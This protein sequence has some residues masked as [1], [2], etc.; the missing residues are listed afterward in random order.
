MSPAPQ[1]TILIIGMCGAGVAAYNALAPSLPP[2]HR[3]VAVNREDFAYWPIGG[4]RAAVVPGWE[5]KI[6]V[7]FKGLT[8][9]KKGN[10]VLGGSEVVHLDLE[11]KVAV[12]DE[13]RQELD[14]SKE[15]HFDYV[16]IATGSE[17]AIPCRPAPGVRTI[18][19]LKVSLQA[20]QRDI[21]AS[22]KVLI[23]GGGPVGI[24][25]AGELISKFGK[26]KQITLLTSAPGLYTD[27][28][29]K[30][31]LGA[32]L[33]KTLIDNGVKLVFG[34]KAF[35]GDLTTGK[36]NSHVLV[37]HA[38]GHNEEIEPDF[39][40]V[41]TGGRPNTSLFASSLLSSS[42]PHR[43]VV[44]RNLQLPAYP[45]AYAIGDVMDIDSK[46]TAAAGAQGPVVAKNVLAALGKGSKVELKDMATMVVVPIGADKGAGQ[47]M[48]MVV[49]GK[50]TSMIKG[51]TLFLS[52]FEKAYAPKSKKKFGIF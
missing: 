21:Q 51:K 20:L 31:A 36:V 34:A 1:E 16:I 13:A 30:P 17:Y 5:D 22:K 44:N 32:S 14:G 24:E 41:G 43:L 33:A 4:L 6:A 8:D 27:P 26:T 23:V 15:I 45:F 46:T 18:A 48:G 39:L 50:V 40:L 52:M 9:G 35:L 42:A 49:G 28:I 19:D 2:T 10:L 38:D 3:I 37:Q 7:P 29:W 47:L 25:F 12:L 11:G